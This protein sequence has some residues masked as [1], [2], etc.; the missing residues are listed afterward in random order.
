MGELALDGTTRPIKG[1]LSMAIAT[2][3]N[4]RL[5]G[6][7]VPADNAA[8][9]AVVEGVAIL[10]VASLTDAAHFF[11]AWYGH[12]RR[13]AVGR[14]STAAAAEICEASL[15]HNYYRYCLIIL[16]TQFFSP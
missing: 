8:E 14:R 3:R 16:P 4:S 9:A 5:D 10:P 1:A 15:G 11:S 13:M 12:F 2:A 7:L 6:L